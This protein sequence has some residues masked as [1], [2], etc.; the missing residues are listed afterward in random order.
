[1]KK[2][3]FGLLDWHL[4][5][6]NLPWIMKNSYGRSKFQVV[7][8]SYLTADSESSQKTDNWKCLSF[9]NIPSGTP[10]K[11]PSKLFHIVLYIEKGR[12]YLFLENWNPILTVFPSEFLKK[13]DTFNYRFFERNLNLQ[14]DLLSKQLEISTS[15][16]IFQN[17]G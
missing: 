15:H 1:M 17:P 4:S 14:S 7:W 6:R 8:I 3:C 13:K 5:T 2:I 16:R 11:I 12:T 9:L 10:S